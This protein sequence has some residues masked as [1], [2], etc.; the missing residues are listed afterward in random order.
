VEDV[1]FPNESK[2][3]AQT[4]K[5]GNGDGAVS[6]QPS[7]ERLQY[8]HGLHIFQGQFS[9]RTREVAGA[10][11]QALVSQGDL[12]VLVGEEDGDEEEERA[13]WWKVGSWGIRRLL[14]LVVIANE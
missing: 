11:D 8:E 2:W 12:G 13:G 7:E 5:A 9:G 10:V 14:S 4:T 6:E 3:Q 1:G